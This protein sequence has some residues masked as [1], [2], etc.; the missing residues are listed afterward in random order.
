[1]RG[2]WKEDE[3]GSLVFIPSGEMPNQQVGIYW[4]IDNEVIKD[5]VPYKEGEPYGEAIQH[6]S[7]YEFWE[8][9]QPTTEIERKLKSRAYDAYPR[10]RVVFFPA[11]K[12]FC[13]YLDRCLDSDDSIRIDE[14]FEIED[15]DIEY[16]DDEHYRCAGC[17]PFFVDI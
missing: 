12:A 15:F 10:G 17:N 8:A 13:I 16:G 5:A 11:R 6:G 2:N 9:L 14:A 4:F 1:M 3:S 7:H